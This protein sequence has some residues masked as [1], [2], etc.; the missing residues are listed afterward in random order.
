MVNDGLAEY[1]ARKPDRFVALGTVPLI[2]GDEAAKELERCMKTLGMK[3][4]E[5]LTNVAGHELSEPAYAPFWQKAE[6]LGALVRHPSQRLH[7]R[8]ALHAL[9]FQQRDRQ[10][11]RDHDRAAL[12][13]LRRRARA[14][15][16]PEDPGGARRRLSAGLFRPHR[17]CLGRALGF[18]RRPAAA[19]DQLSQEDLFRHGGVHARIS[20]PSWCGC[21][22]PTTS[23][24]AP[25]IRSTWPTTIRSATSRRSTASTRRPSRRYRRQR[26]R[27]LGL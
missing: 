18:A 2:D 9:L 27:L 20:S 8:Q 6:E 23:S 15:P 4:V 21:S 17:P 16:Q 22:A 11:A 24:W 10:S 26:T 19:A 7:R 13:D 12:P 3:G 14:P 1:V 5:I 25:T